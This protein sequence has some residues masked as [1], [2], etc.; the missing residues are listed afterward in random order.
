[1]PLR[2]RTGPRGEGSRTGRGLGDCEL[3]TDLT[4]E[5]KLPRGLGMGRGLGINSGEGTQKGLDSIS[6]KIVKKIL[7][8]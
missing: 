3:K 5:S 4:E 7:N 8:K 6:E 1:M 2:D